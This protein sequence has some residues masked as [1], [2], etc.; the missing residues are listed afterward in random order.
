MDSN[1][2]DICTIIT[3]YATEYPINVDDQDSLI[4]IY[5]LN[6]VGIYMFARPYHDIKLS[7]TLKPE[8]NLKE[9]KLTYDTYNVTN[10][11][12]NHNYIP[13][14]Q[15]PYNLPYVDHFPIDQFILQSNNHDEILKVV[16]SDTSWITPRLSQLVYCII[17]KIEKIF[18]GSIIYNDDLILSMN[19]IKI[20]LR[21]TIIIGDLHVYSLTTDPNDIKMGINFARIDQTKLGF[22]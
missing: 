14:D 13:S 8:H 5:L 6:V 12:I 19:E 10:K 16:D 22:N 1:C 17:L 9:I 18:G 2:R 4:P 21:P 3:E 20:R 7:F 11:P 15:A